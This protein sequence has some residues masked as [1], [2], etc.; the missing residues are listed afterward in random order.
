[1]DVNTSV[2]PDLRR[3]L[4]QRACLPSIAALAMLVACAAPAAAQSVPSGSG[5]RAAVDSAWHRALESAEA[6]S[7][8][9][10]AAANRT[11]AQALVPASPALEL[12]Q[13]DER[14]AAE[15]AS[16]AGRETELAAAWPLWL[17]GQRALRAAAADA[18][19]N[20]AD[21]AIALG[22]WQVA[23][24]VREAAWR[25]ASGRDALRQAELQQQTLERLSSDVERRVRAG[26]LAR[27]DALAAQAEALGAATATADA[28]L[29]LAE[30]E[31]QWTLLT[32]LPPPAGGRPAESPAASPPP[33]EAHPAW[34]HAESR[35]EQARREQAAVLQDRRDP[36]ELLLRYR[37][38]AGAGDTRNSIGLGMRIPFGSDARNRP[39]EAQATGAVLVAERRLARLRDRLAVELA[40]AADAREAAQQRLRDDEQRAALARERAQLSQRAF[41]AG[42]FG[43]PELLRTLSAAAAAQADLERSQAALGLA[44]A[45]LLQAQGLM[46]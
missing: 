25:I 33:L 13:R 20:A 18:Q 17:P 31:R 34:R 2:S 35:R 14:W 11:A 21:A 28:R 30:A 45:R 42:E 4:A 29:R 44:R 26:D 39:L 24:L 27:A 16:S 41:D 43:L 12:S 38:E 22:R 3:T 15:R 6:D 23:G 9:L 40:L 1:M 7:D 32:A 19:S 46:P 8:V 36:P 5:L 37:Q 10:R